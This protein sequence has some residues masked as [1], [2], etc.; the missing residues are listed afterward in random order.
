MKKPLQVTKLEATGYRGVYVQLSDPSPAFVGQ[1]N[2]DLRVTFV[3]GPVDDYRLGEWVTVTISRAR[4][5]R[6]EEMAA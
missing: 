3:A 2:P 5:Q 4:D 6:K 1:V